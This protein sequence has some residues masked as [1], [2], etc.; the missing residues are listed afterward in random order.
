[1]QKTYAVVPPTQIYFRKGV[2]CNTLLERGFHVVELPG[3]VF[4]KHM[5]CV[6]NLDTSR[7]YTA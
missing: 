3:V 6:R 7:N 2:T 4:L 5:L 1:M